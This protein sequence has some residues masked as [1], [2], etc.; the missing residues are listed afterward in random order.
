[1][2]NNETEHYLYLDA[3]KRP[4]DLYPI[5]IALAILT[6]R[7]ALYCPSVQYIHDQA[8]AQQLKP[9]LGWLTDM[10]AIVPMGSAEQLDEFW[11]DPAR[12]APESFI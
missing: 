11:P 4:D 8:F 9:I 7:V 3:N 12:G 1:M 2:I 5:A 10:R 6:G